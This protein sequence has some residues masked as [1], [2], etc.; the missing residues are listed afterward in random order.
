MVFVVERTRTCHPGPSILP[1]LIPGLGQGLLHGLSGPLLHY[2][3]DVAV[4][5]VLPG[6][7]NP[8]RAVSFK[9][10]DHHI[11]LALVLPQISEEPL[12]LGVVLPDPL[13]TAL[14]PALNIGRVKSQT[15]VEDL[16]VVAVVV[17]YG[18]P[19]RE[20]LFSSPTG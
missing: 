10:F 1:G 14:D 8:D 12:F 2:R 6:S 19:A 7:A 13:Q 3:G 17:A 20:A 9:A 11:P 5:S 4:G 18:S 15:Q 16:C